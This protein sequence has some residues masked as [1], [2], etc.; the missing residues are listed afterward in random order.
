LLPPEAAGVVAALSIALTAANKQIVVSRKFGMTSKIAVCSKIRHDLYC[1]PKNW[2][3]NCCSRIT[4]QMV[5]ITKDQN[6]LGTKTNQS[7]CNNKKSKQCLHGNGSIEPVQEE[8][9]GDLTG[10]F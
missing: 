5:N 4:Q 2:H 1:F 9:E 3:K 6:V 10:C 8:E 7:N